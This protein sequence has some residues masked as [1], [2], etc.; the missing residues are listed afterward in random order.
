LLFWHEAIMQ[1]VATSRGAQITLM[2]T[3]FYLLL[4]VARSLVIKP[5]VVVAWFVLEASWL[6]QAIV[7]LA[8]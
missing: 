4:Q 8:S 1:L 6:D 5:C 3:P 2:A 7:L